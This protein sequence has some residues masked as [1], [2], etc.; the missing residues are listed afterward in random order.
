MAGLNNGVCNMFVCGT[1]SSFPALRRQLM[2]AHVDPSVM[3]TIPIVIDVRMHTLK[4]VECV[5]VL[6]DRS[7]TSDRGA[8]N[9]DV[10]GNC[11]KDIELDNCYMV[12]MGVE[13]RTL[14]LLAPRSKPTELLDRCYQAT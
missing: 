7:R 9:H 2:R 3:V 14:A 6:G 10:Q 11:Q 1:D 5:V 8:K 12:N 4:L 13:P